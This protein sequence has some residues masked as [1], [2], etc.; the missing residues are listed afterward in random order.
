MKHGT[1]PNA[2][3]AVRMCAQD[4]SCITCLSHGGHLGPCMDLA[5]RSWTVFHSKCPIGAGSILVESSN[6]FVENLVLINALVEFKGSTLEQL[7]G[8]SFALFAF[9]RFKPIAQSL[10][11]TAFLWEKPTSDTSNTQLQF[12]QAGRPK[13]NW[14]VN[15]LV[16]VVLW[17]SD[18]L[19]AGPSYCLVVGGSGMKGKKSCACS[20][21]RTVFPCPEQNHNQIAN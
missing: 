17:W 1:I 16:C 21:T 8:V 14:K 7:A 3:L 9:K 18:L 5:R 6:H 20:K 12:V 10:K 4:I 11:W 15:F 2:I 13:E 19:V